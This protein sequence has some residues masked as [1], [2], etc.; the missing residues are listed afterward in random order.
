MDNAIKYSSENGQIDVMIRKTGTGAD[1]IVSNDVNRITKEQTDRMFDRFYRADESRSE[2]AG[3]GLG[4]SIAKAVCE[5]H[6][7][8]IKAETLSDGKKIR[9]TARLS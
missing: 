2:K 3:Y 1:L 7:G 4:L 6:G 8:G 9:I 5:A